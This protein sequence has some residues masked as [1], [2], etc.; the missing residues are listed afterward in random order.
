MVVGILLFQGKKKVTSFERACEVKG[1]GSK[2]ICQTTSGNDFK[3]Y[4]DSGSCAVS[5]SNQE[6]SDVRREPGFTK[7]A[8]AET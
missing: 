7:T 2:P 6:D 3:M 8:Y 4:A 5:G 1:V